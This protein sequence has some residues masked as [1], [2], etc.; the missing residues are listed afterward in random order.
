MGGAK[1]QLALRHDN[2]AS[3]VPSAKELRC[4][5]TKH[6]TGKNPESVAGCAIL[7]WYERRAFSWPFRWAFPEDIYINN[8]NLLEHSSY[9]FLSIVYLTAINGVT[10]TA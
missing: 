1:A 2:T 7:A 10:I 9:T 4:P 5:Y 3:A 8:L 6:S